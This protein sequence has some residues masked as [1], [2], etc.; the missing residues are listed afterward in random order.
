MMMML[1]TALQKLSYTNDDNDEMD[2]HRHKYFFMPQYT[3]GIVFIK[4][5]LVIVSHKYVVIETNMHKILKL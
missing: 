2:Q 1:M 5:C 3:I 4:T